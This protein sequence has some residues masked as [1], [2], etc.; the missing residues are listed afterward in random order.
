M[1]R[2]VP[3]TEV[4]LVHHHHLSSTHRLILKLL[5]VSLSLVQRFQ[6]WPIYIY[7]K[8][9]KS[10]SW[11]VPFTNSTIKGFVTWTC[12]PATSIPPT[13]PPTTMKSGPARDTVKLPV[14]VTVPLLSVFEKVPDILVITY[15]P[16]I[17]KHSK[18]KNRSHTIPKQSSNQTKKDMK[19]YT[20][21]LTNPRELL[22][23]SS[24]IDTSPKAERTQTWRGS[25]FINATNLAAM[26]WVSTME[27][28]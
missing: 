8:K 24:A 27:R 14:L 17:Y 15:G 20:S 25:W 18:K 28:S 21:Y 12:E 4:I 26:S 22:D 7:I 5:S 16:W 23:W 9:A 19:C 3:E 11:R 1:T 6:Q 10:V 2:L 13:K